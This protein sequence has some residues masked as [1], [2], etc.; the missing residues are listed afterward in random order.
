M[1]SVDSKR[2]FRRSKEDIFVVHEYKTEI[3]IE[4]YFEPLKKQDCLIIDCQK[5][6]IT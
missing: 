2:T 3:L 4:D 1:A 6:K 5:F